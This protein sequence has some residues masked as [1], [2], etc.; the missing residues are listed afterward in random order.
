MPP[1][2]AAGT[3]VPAKWMKPTLKCCGRS[4]QQRAAGK[5]LQIY[6]FQNVVWKVQKSL[7]VGRV[8]QNQVK[9]IMMHG[10]AW[11]EAPLLCKRKSTKVGDSLELSWPFGSSVHLGASGPQPETVI[12]IRCYKYYM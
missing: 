11:S 3:N 12:N 10:L 8:K 6:I 9:V 4:W 7:S 2:P 5:Y 1:L